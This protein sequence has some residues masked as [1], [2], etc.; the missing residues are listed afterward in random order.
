MIGDDRRPLV[1]GQA[2][3]RQRPVPH[4]AHDQA[5]RQGEDFAGP[6]GAQVAGGPHEPVALET[7][8]RDPAA[9]AFDLHRR[10]PETQMN[11]ARRACPFAR[12]ERAQD[13]QV[14]LRLGIVPQLL[15]AARVELEL[16][17]IHDEI[18]AL[19]MG[20]LLELRRRPLRLHR[21]AAHEE[22]DVA[23]TA[24]PQAGERI[25]GDVRRR[26][27]LR[28]PPQNPRHVD[29]DVAGADDRRDR[30]GKVDR[31]VEEIRVSAVP[32]DQRRRGM[33]PRE[34]LPRNPEPAVARTADG[35][36]A[37]VVM[38]REIADREVPAQLDVAQEAHPRVE[39]H[40]LE[41][42]HDLLDLGMV[43]GDSEAHQ[44]IGSG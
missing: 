14:L 23:D 39:R 25:V 22:V 36:G 8:S 33:A 20:E 15:L 2:G 30:A 37:G 24:R 41:H 19:E 9:G 27:V 38:R 43:R 21:A 12:G 10:D 29:G 42:P 11:P 6:L 5:R 31:Q 16:A 28:I 7:H 44:A 13:L 4:R 3:E 40:A 35:E 17:R 18:D 26:Q 34:I 1:E 32:G